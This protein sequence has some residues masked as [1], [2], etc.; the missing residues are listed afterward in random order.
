MNYLSNNSLAYLSDENIYQS[1]FGIV[2]NNE[3]IDNDDNNN[4][5]GNEK[6]FLTDVQI[7]KLLENYE[8]KNKNKNKNKKLLFIIL[9]I[10]FLLLV[11][12]LI[13]F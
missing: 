11:F 8:N 3:I 5:V 10:L 2:E 7:E 13:S 4:E 12:C 1:T 6:N 9:F